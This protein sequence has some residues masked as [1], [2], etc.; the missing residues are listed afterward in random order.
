MPGEG[1]FD[2]EM[3]IFGRHIVVSSGCG[4][5]GIK[6]ANPSFLEPIKS[7][8]TGHF[9]DEMT[10]NIKRVGMAF[11][12]LYDVVIPDFIK[13]GL[14]CQSKQSLVRCSLKK[15]N[16]PYAALPSQDG[17]LVFFNRMMLL[18]FYFN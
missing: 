8:R 18:H 10:V 11:F 2:W 9:M 4:A 6:N 15:R 16:R 13:N 12:V 3:L 7:L 17:S 5:L 14:R 1:F